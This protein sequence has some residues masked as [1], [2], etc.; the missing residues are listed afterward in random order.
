MTPYYWR[1]SEADKEKLLGVES[2]KTEVEFEIY[3]YKKS[4]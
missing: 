3:V 2:L 4:H 1:T